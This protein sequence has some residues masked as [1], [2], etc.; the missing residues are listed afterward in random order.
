MCV[1][2]Q[3]RPWPQHVVC[4]S[5]GGLYV[6]CVRYRGHKPAVAG[7]VLQNQAGVAYECTFIHELPVILEWLV[8]PIAD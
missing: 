1:S 4:F 5:Y 6:S 3:G 7:Q 2:E 8:S